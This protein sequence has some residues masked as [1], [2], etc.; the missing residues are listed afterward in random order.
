M[1]A[2]STCFSRQH[3]YVAT[4]DHLFFL[5]APQPPRWSAWEVGRAYVELGIPSSTLLERTLAFGSG[6]DGAGDAA[7]DWGGHF[8]EV[9]EGVCGGWKFWCC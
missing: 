5:Q 4:I 9:E 3:I 2:I 6:L 1:M 7:G 8:S